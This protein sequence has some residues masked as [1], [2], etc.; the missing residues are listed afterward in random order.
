LKAPGSDQRFGVNIIARPTSFL[1]NQILAVQTELRKVAPSQ[2]YYPASDLHLTVVEISSGGTQALSEELCAAA[3]SEFAKVA[4][5]LRPSMISGA[6]IRFDNH[7]G[8]VEFHESETL[9]DMRR[10]II[11][12]LKEV[13]IDIAPRYISSSAHITFMRYLQQLTN[14]V[15]SVVSPAKLQ[16]DWLLNE[17]WLTCGATWYGMRSRI[18]EVGPF[19]L[20]ER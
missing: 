10:E 17:L 14:G 15:E 9:N 4:D 11:L 1:K 19:E 16:G 5:L 2:Y 13:G 20:A 3:R 6:S 18:Q 8:I 12:R 7:A